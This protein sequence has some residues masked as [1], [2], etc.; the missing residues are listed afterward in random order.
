MRRKKAPAP[1]AHHFKILCWAPNSHKLSTT[2]WTEGLVNGNISS[3]TKQKGGPIPGFVTRF[4]YILFPVVN[5]VWM[6]KWHSSNY[7]YSCN[8]SLKGSGGWGWRWGPLYN[9]DLGKSDQWHSLA[10]SLTLRVWSVQAPAQSSAA[11][12]PLRW[13][14]AWCCSWPNWCC[15]LRGASIHTATLRLPGWPAALTAGWS[16]HIYISLVKYVT[17][18]PCAHQADQPQWLLGDLHTQTQSV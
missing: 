11:P 7:S 16:A 6:W 2:V 1:K 3:N 15:V 13:L 17:R 4:S 14:P 5:I 9:A 12:S 8:L 10:P 18:Q